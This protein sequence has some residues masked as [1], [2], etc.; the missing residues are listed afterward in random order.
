M[1]FQSVGGIRACGSIG[2]ARKMCLLCYPVVGKGSV[3]ELRDFSRGGEY[4]DVLSA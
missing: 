2:M 1:S 4:V 3:A